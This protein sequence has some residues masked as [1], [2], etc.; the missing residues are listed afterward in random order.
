MKQPSH[1]SRTPSGTETSSTR[2]DSPGNRKHRSAQATNKGQMSHG[3]DLSTGRSTY[4]TT[5]GHQ[6]P[7]Q[8]KTSQRPCAGRM[9]KN[10]MSHGEHS[11]H[12]INHAT[13]QETVLDGIGTWARRRH[14][15]TMGFSL[16]IECK[17]KKLNVLTNTVCNGYLPEFNIWRNDNSRRKS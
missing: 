11:R 1:S 13:R 3:E 7:S 9:R 17:Q 6:N 8:P 4:H 15:Q 5:Q 16:K 10:K 14:K 2:L 12:S